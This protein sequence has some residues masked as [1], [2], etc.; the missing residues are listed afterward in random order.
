MLEGKCPKCEYLVF[1]WALRDQKFQFCPKCNIKLEITEDGNRIF[2]GYSLFTL[3]G[4]PVKPPANVPTIH[5][6]DK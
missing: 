2:N 5:D 3:E 6:N 4:Y 1:G